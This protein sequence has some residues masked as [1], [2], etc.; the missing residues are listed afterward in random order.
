VKAEPKSEDDFPDTIRAAA[1]HFLKRE[2]G[3][4]DPH[5][6]QKRSP[7]APGVNEDAPPK[8]KAEPES[9]DDF[10]DTVRAAATHFLK[11]EQDH[12]DPQGQKRGPNAPEVNDEEMQRTMKAYAI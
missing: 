2:Q 3:D 6:G 12:H 9:N 1:T 4:H 10:P 5:Q 8:M 7:N 11:R